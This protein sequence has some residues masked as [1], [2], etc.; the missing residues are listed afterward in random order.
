[1]A[2][3]LPLVTD[4]TTSPDTLREIAVG[5]TIPPEHTLPVGGTAGQVLTKQS[6]TDGD[7]DWATPA[8]TQ[9]ELDAEAALRL[10]G[11]SSLLAAQ[12]AHHGIGGSTH[13]VAI[14]SG[15]A[16]F[17]SGAD[18][19]KLDGIAA[20]AAALTSSTPADVA[21]AGAVGVGTTAARSDHAHAHGSQLGGALHAAA[22]E[23]AA[24]FESVADKVKIDDVTRLRELAAAAGK[25]IAPND[26]PNSVDVLMV[27]GQNRWRVGTDTTGYVS[28]YFYAEMPASL[29]YSTP[30][31]VFKSNSNL[32]LYSPIGVPNSGSP[33]SNAAANTEATLNASMFWDEGIPIP[34]NC[35]VSGAE[36]EID[37]FG[38]IKIGRP[39]VL[40]FVLDPDGDVRLAYTGD[41]STL[42]AET[43]KCVGADSATQI[44]ELG[45]ITDS[46]GDCL[47][48][49]LGHGLVDDQRVWLSSGDRTKGIMPDLIESGYYYVD[50]VTDDT[51]KPSTT[52]IA[53]ATYVPYNPTLVMGVPQESTEVVVTKL[54]SSGSWKQI[55]FAFDLATNTSNS[56]FV[57]FR[58]SIRGIAEGRGE[59]DTE[60]GVIWY[61]DLHTYEVS[62]RIG[63]S[64]TTVV[65]TE[66][67]T[68]SKHWKAAAARTSPGKGWVAP[69]ALW[70]TGAPMLLASNDYDGSGTDS[71]ITTAHDYAGQWD[72]VML[73]ADLT[74]SVPFKSITSSVNNVEA[75]TT[76]L[77][78]GGSPVGEV[79]EVFNGR[80]LLRYRPFSEA[81]RIKSG[82]SVSFQIYKR[83]AGTYS[84]VAGATGTFTAGAVRIGSQT[85]KL[86]MRAAMDGLQN[87]VNVL[88]VRGG[89]A[90][91][92]RNPKRSQ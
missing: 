17:Q 1:M 71:F 4:T 90:R 87:G 74:A 51:F 92:I 15:A 44:A 61:A 70:P 85:T 77:S 42:A 78:V 33:A 88:D 9:A 13:P 86:A 84:A 36:I 81:V 34:P 30:P 28:A 12:T 40:Y 73:S 19:A 53:G 27:F 66:G 39:G 16:G 69:G 65:V 35:F 82:D 45:D 29:T 10:A 6:G 76:L 54:T 64:T 52:P 59:S 7:A 22:S 14:A 80:R 31:E 26:S 18:K 3:I 79:L 43:H 83:V 50:K 91:L 32:A 21:A 60:D 58:L 56:D 72:E 63:T 57:P 89:V 25:L 41:N 37:L 67:A 75:T 68:A 24:G 47:V 46:G 23:N 11:D 20:G 38:Q 2:E 55:K 5:E 62:D 49:L 48:T 8:V